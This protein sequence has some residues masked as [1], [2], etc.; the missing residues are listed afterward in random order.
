MASTTPCIDSEH[1]LCSAESFNMKRI[2]SDNIL[3]YPT[4]PAVSHSYGWSLWSGSSHLRGTQLSWA[5]C[6]HG[7][8]LWPKKTITDWW[9]SMWRLHVMLQNL[10]CI[11]IW[12][13]LEDGAP[14][15]VDDTQSLVLADGTDNAAVFVPADTVDKVWVGISQLVH[16]LPCAQVPH[17]NQVITA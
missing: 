14:P 17:T 9:S 12:V 15:W 8:S 3:P 6:H 13:D 10:F 4:T 2:Y 5:W 16:Q 11:Y 7:P 1:E